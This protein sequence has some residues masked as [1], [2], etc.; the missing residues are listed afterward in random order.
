MS[1][2][3]PADHRS[4]I[5]EMDRWDRGGMYV[6]VALTKNAVIVQWK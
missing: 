3:N 4:V 1:G 6:V 5:V 2:P